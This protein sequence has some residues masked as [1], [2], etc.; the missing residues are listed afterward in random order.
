MTF[1]TMVFGTVISIL[2][3]I[4]DVEMVSHIVVSSTSKRDGTK[5]SS[6]GGSK[7]VYYGL[8]WRG[9]IVWRS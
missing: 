3:G 2:I 7:D 8:S 5:V 9:H 1:A 6:K 4:V